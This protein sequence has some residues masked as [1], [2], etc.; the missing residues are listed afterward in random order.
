MRSSGHSSL[1]QGP[2]SSLHNMEQFPYK[3]KQPSVLQIN[4]QQPALR[5]VH[6]CPH[7]THYRGVVVKGRGLGTLRLSNQED[8]LRF[9]KLF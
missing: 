7:H 1:H 9:N 4:T 5:L 8:Q 6:T 3:Q 2:P